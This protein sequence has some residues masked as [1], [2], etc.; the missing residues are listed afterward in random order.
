[1]LVEWLK[2]GWEY[3]FWSVVID[4]PEVMFLLST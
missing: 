3:A 4:I 2:D 1:M